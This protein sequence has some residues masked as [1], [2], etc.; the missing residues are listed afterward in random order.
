MKRSA[1]TK[2]R[3]TAFHATTKVAMDTITVSVDPASG[4][5]EMAEADPASYRSV[6]YYERSSG[7]DKVLL[8]LPGSTRAN[9]FDAMDQLTDQ[10]SHVVAVDTN[11]YQ[12]DGH[13]FAVACVFAV[14]DAL[15]TASRTVRAVFLNAF[16]IIDPSPTV[17]PERIG[18]HLTLKRNIVP[19]RFGSTDRVALVVDS[20]LGQLEMINRQ[21]APYYENNL[22]PAYVSLIYAS[23]DNPTDSLPSD[24]IRACDAHGRVIARTHMHSTSAVPLEAGDQNYGG[25]YCVGPDWAANPYRGSAA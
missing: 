2:R 5:V 8:Q 23:S 13:T 22:L 11:K 20:E 18:W 21:E 1:R 9:A 19:G 12:G 3:L 14:P 24:F 25:L 7:K 17:N 15:T 16:V 10:F 6:V 4:F